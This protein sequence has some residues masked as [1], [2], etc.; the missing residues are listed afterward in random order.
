ME[1]LVRTARAKGVMILPGN[2]FTISGRSIRATRLGF[3]S[4]NA[5]ELDSAT[6]RL[7]QALGAV[8]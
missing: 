2:A 5:A 8:A 4:M 3:A 1:G 7:R 6:R